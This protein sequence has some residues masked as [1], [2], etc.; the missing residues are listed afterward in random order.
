[1]SEGYSTEYIAHIGRF[2]REKAKESVKLKRISRR[3]LY[4]RLLEE[5]TRRKYALLH[6]LENDF[7]Y[8]ISTLNE[9]SGNPAIPNEKAAN[10][11]RE[12]IGQF[13][14]EQYEAG[15][16][17]R[18]RD[19][20]L[21]SYL[22]LFT[23]MLRSGFSSLLKIE[24]FNPPCVL[25]NC[26]DE[27]QWPVSNDVRRAR[28]YFM[29]EIQ[30][31][32]PF[33]ETGAMLDEKVVLQIL[34]ASPSYRAEINDKKRKNAMCHLLD[35]APCGFE[36]LKVLSEL[37]Q[38]G[39]TEAQIVQAETR[40]LERVLSE[41]SLRE[42]SALLPENTAWRD[43]GLTQTQNY[44]AQQT[45]PCNLEALRGTFGFSP[46]LEQIEQSMH[47]YLAE[48]CT[49][50]RRVERLRK[51]LDDSRLSG[52]RAIYQEIGTQYLA[53]TAERTGH[54]DKL[55]TEFNHQASLQE[56]LDMADRMVKRIKGYPRMA[57]MGLNWPC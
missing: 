44:A 31:M 7:P 18:Y 48:A 46:S 40:K 38:A 42:A 28:A 47:G 20:Q 36:E 41:A 49:W 43:Y 23:H 39:Y 19:L 25:S 3:D 56:I 22:V 15:N 26:L 1:M 11:Y 34:K 33:S 5:A 13:W 4:E 16:S 55:K 53:S 51:I 21:C 52:Q 8:S 27:S 30:K 12:K 24:E 29:E 9:N 14:P 57:S 17:A 10:L 54:L 6:E 2:A 32:Q 45:N 50:D 37:L 35:N